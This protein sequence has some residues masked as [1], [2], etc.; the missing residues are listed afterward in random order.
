MDQKLEL[1]EL[2]KEDY[3]K[4][5][6]FSAE[7]MDFSAYIKNKWLCDL[8]AKYLTYVSIQDGTDL[9]AAYYNNELV[10][11]LLV[12]LYDQ[13]KKYHSLWQKFYMRCFD[14]FQY[15][16]Q[17]KGIAQFNI[18]NEDMLTKYKKEVELDGEI[19]LFATDP[20]SPLKGVGSFLLN[21]LSKIA[22]SKRLF[23]YT[24]SCCNHGFYD[25]KGFE[26]IDEMELSIPLRKD[27][28]EHVKAILYSR[29]FKAEEFAK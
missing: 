16:F 12:E 20:N 4:V 14:L 10:G 15:T 19:H 17:M 7:G 25:Y 22:D 28:N 1:R 3:K 9:L 27:P 11:F 18:A 23:L 29:K 24:D 21:E 5:A 13:P 8:Y 6:A 2:D 26:K